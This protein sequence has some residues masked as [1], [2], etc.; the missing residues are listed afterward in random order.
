MDWFTNV[1]FCLGVEVKMRIG[2]WYRDGAFF[3]IFFYVVT[4]IMIDIINVLC[5]E[6]VGNLEIGI[7][8]L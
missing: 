6:I 7:N 5:I 4:Y 8:K 3:L 1:N 2:L